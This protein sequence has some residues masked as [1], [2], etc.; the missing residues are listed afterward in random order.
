MSDSEK[1]EAVKLTPVKG[2]PD[3][4]LKKDIKAGLALDPEEESQK[5]SAQTP[6]PNVTSVTSGDTVTTTT[7]TGG[8]TTA[9]TDT[10]TTGATGTGVTR[11][12]G[13]SGS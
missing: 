12:T 8:T 10:S 11:T 5:T 13:A 4:V 2:I 3:H 1:Y 7:A 6:D 9:G